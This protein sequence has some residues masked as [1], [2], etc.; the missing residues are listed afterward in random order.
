MFSVGM[1]TFNALGARIGLGSAAGTAKPEE[2]NH[3]LQGD[4][5]L[6]DSTHILET[7]GDLCDVLRL[8]TDTHNAAKR[9]VQQASA[10]EVFKKTITYEIIICC[11][12]IA[13]REENQP[14]TF[15]KIFAIKG[16]SLPSSLRVLNTIKKHLAD[17]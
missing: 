4:T 14:R 1:R 11:L 5:V 16:L 3:T 10:L 9:L 2:Q 7:L 8:S 6:R 17:R 13:C 12:F 15:G